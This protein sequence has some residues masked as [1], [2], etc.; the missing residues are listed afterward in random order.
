MTEGINPFDRVAEEARQALDRA[1]SAREAALGLSRELVRAS[2]N[3]I[4]ATHRSDRDTAEALLQRAGD[5]A[6]QLARLEEERADI[7]FTGYV[8][9]SL[10]EFAEARVVHALVNDL[11]VPD[12][13]ALEIPWPPYLNGLGEAVGEMR[14][15]CLDLLR[16]RNTARAEAILETMDAIYTI[17]V[18]IDY[19]DALTNG[20][21]RTTDMVRGILERTRADLTTAVLQGRLARDMERLAAQLSQDNVE[22]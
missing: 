2:A 5:L 17:L 19:P 1:N 9:D 13:G 21:R 15:Y 10:K 16:L 11:P 4:R 3:S 12:A 18:T 6:V 20:L 22:P 8:Q 14:R 7:F